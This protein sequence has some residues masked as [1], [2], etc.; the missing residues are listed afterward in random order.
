[1][2]WF[3]S[4]EEIRSEIYLLSEENQKH[5][6]VL[7]LRDGEAVTVITPNGEQCDC[8]YKSG[9][10]LRFASRRKVAAQKA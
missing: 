3:F 5:A 2:A 1:M 7:R 6:R 4:E 8:A 9:G 10:T